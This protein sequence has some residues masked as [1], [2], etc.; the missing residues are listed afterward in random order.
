MSYNACSLKNHS[1]AVIIRTTRSSPAITL[2]L[3]VQ[4]GNVCGTYG[5]KNRVRVRA[6]TFLAKNITLSRLG[7]TKHF[8][9]HK[10]NF[11]EYMQD[12][13]QKVP[14]FGLSDNFFVIR[15]RL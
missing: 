14:Q 4:G 10:G 3:V 6:Q 9:Y 11:K 8:V 7:V 2:A 1:S 12:V 15:F 5:N 13:L